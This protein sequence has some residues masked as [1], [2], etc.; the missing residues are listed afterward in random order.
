MAKVAAEALASHPSPPN[1]APAG[2]ASS[3]EYYSDAGDADF[4]V[5]ICSAPTSLIGSRDAPR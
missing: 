4:H 2:S 1:A 5:S 3:S